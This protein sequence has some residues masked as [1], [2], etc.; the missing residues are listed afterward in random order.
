MQKWRT[1]EKQ[2]GQR[3]VS[4]VCCPLSDTSGEQGQA[5]PAAAFSCS[6]AAFQTAGTSSQ[7]LLCR[8]SYSKHPALLHASAQLSYLLYNIK[9]SLSLN[10]SPD[11]I[12]AGIWIFE[13]QR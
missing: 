10:P 11:D 8:V 2:S 13:V 7:H 4:S 1:E 6:N 12:C 3:M 9:P 5:Q